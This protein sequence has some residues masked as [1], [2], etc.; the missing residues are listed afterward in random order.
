[1]SRASLLGLTLALPALGAAFFA[2]QKEDPRPAVSN[3]P[4]VFDP[5]G[6]RGNGEEGGIEGGAGT[7]LATFPGFVPSGL[8]IDDDIA[9]VTLNSLSAGQ[10]GEVVQVTPTGKVTVL[11]SDAVVP[12]LPIFG[13]NAVFYVDAPNGGDRSV[14]KLD[15]ANVSAGEQPLLSGLQEPTGMIVGG[16]SLFVVSSAG[17]TG[18]EVDSVPVLGGPP[19]PVTSLGGDFSPG[20]IAL[21][22]SNVYFVAASA[23]ASEI[24]SA[25]LA[26]GPAN[27]L[28]SGTPGTIG[29]LQVLGGMIYYS[30]IANPN[31]GI[32][33]ASVAGGASSTIVGGLSNPDAFGLADGYVYFIDTDAAGSISRA[34]VDDDAGVAPELLVSTVEPLALG[35]GT[36]SIYVITQDGIIRIPR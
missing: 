32:A 17:G 14:M 25:P 18:V 21:D 1:M 20:A 29:P 30:V 4:G 5:A 11:V 31:S 27:P 6:G 26:G 35:V 34:L 36:T 33:V 22:A 24:A 10:S 9:I 13:S 7:E 28:I 16:N 2:C 19:T 12:T 15:L 8:A 3:G 23:G